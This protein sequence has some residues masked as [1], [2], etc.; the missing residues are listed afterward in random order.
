LEALSLF[1]D[2]VVCKTKEVPS[3]QHIPERCLAY[4]FNDPA[5][6][7]ALNATYRYWSGFHPSVTL[8]AVWLLS[9]LKYVSSFAPLK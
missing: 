4:Q 7:S 8:T 3:N 2:S 6:L 1:L 5:V 9:H